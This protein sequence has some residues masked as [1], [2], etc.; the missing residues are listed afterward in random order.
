MKTASQ[1]GYSL[2]YTKSSSGFQFVTVRKEH[3]YCEFWVDDNQIYP[4]SKND[5]GF[6]DMPLSVIQLIRFWFGSITFEEYDR[7]LKGL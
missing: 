1:A 2:T 3:D 4:S 5:F 6:F 7:A